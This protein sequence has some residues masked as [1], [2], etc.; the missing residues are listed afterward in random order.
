MGVKRHLFGGRSALLCV[1][2]VAGVWAWA[3]GGQRDVDRED[4]A[5]RVWLVHHFIPDFKGG[6]LVG[7]VSATA[8]DEDMKALD[9]L[10]ELEF[11]NIG[12]TH[13]GERGLKHLR[14]LTSLRILD[15]GHGVTDAVMPHI[16][17]LRRLENL[18]LRGASISDSGLKAI[19]SLETLKDLDLFGTNVSDQGLSALSRMKN[20]RDLHLPTSITDEGLVHLEGLSQIRSLKLSNNRN[21]RD[22]GL[23]HL[24]KLSQL[25][26][27]DCGGTNIG[28]EGV[29]NIRDLRE[30]RVLKMNGTRIGDPAMAFIG[31]MSN[32]RELTLMGVDI[33]DTGLE[34]LRSLVKL[35][36]LNIENID[37][38]TEKAISK[39]QA[40]IPGL[41]I[42]H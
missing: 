16:G 29:R 18:S 3:S 15:P 22:H 23:A 34:Q 24:S 8:T 20:L 14:G 9:G 35:K 40:D 27:L 33:T 26:V 6:R 32:L 42:D 30:L 4:A 17:E 13:I 12:P 10:D 19:S 37:N 39:I 11:L 25:E 1:V 5:E 2:C 28:N 36:R 21:I 41:R 38:I 31:A 7:L